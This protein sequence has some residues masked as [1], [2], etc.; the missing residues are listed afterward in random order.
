MS[1]W[2]TLSNLNLGDEEMA[3]R[4]E[5]LSNVHYLEINGNRLTRVPDRCRLL[6]SLRELNVGVNRITSLPN[7]LNELGYLEG[8]YAQGNALT[9]LPPCFPKL[10][11]LTSIDLPNNPSLPQDVGR[12]SGGKSACD[13]FRK[14]LGARYR[15]CQEAALLLIGLLWRRKRVAKD[16]AKMIG[17][18][19]WETRCSSRWG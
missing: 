12:F 14:F 8:I 1:L 7:W 2:V 13:E 10:T 15:K 6:T 3:R 5:S 9:G 11:R 18:M 17:A 19:L 16:V 4:L